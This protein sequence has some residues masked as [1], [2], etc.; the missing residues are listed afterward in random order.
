MGG[1]AALLKTRCST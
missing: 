1:L